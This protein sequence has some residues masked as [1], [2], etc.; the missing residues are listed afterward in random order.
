M[1]PG[2]MVVV[3]KWAK[4][5]K[6]GEYVGEWRVK[7]DPETYVGR[8]GQLRSKDGRLAQVRIVGVDH[9][10]GRGDVTHFVVSTDFSGE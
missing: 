1:E 8:T 6:T 7:G 10:W 4:S 9:D 5:T 2:S 3:G